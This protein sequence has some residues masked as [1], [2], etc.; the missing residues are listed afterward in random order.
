MEEVKLVDTCPIC[1]EEYG[2][3][4]ISITKCGHKF[5]TSCFVE[6]IQSTKTSSCPIC[7]TDTRLDRTEEEKLEQIKRSQQTMNGDIRRLIRFRI[8]QERMMNE[9]AERLEEQRKKERE[10]EL[11]QERLIAERARFDNMVNMMNNKKIVNKIKNKEKIL[12]KY[13]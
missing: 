9:E 4:D 3:K 1:Y 10:E 13:K 11:E 7:R 5:H 6:T 2:G 8:E 12:I